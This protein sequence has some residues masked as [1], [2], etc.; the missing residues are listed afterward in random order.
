MLCEPAVSAAVEHEAVRV[1]PLPASA[2]AEQP[3]SDVPPS[4]K[5]TLPVGLVPVTVAVKVTL[6]PALDGL[7]E[8]TSV[9]VV[10]PPPAFVTLTVSALD[11]APVTMMFTP[12]VLSR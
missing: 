10:E 12:Y 5:F 1:F 6:D 4:A 7:T 2:T 8:L 3:A 9:V 11:V